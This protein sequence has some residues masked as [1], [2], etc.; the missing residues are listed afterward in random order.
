MSGEGAPAPRAARQRDDLQVENARLRAA[1]AAAESERSALLRFLSSPLIAMTHLRRDGT[2]LF[3]NDVGAQNM[4]GRP[5]DFEGRS[6]FEVIP[7]LEAQTRERI[8][9]TLDTGE[10]LVT[11]SV[12]SLPQGEKWFRSTYYP[13]YD[14]T[15]KPASV[16]LVSQ[17]ITDLKRTEQALEATEHRL[18]GVLEHAPHVVV[19]LDPSGVIR[20]INRAPGG[21]EAR[22]FGSEAASH[23]RPESAARFRAAVERV[24]ATAEPE[25]LE[26][27]DASG[28]Y[29]EVRVAP[30][31]RNGGI[32]QLLAFAVDVSD[33]REAQERERR[34]EAQLL[35]S[36]KLESLGVLAGG[37]AHDFNNL[38]VGVL[39]NAQLAQRHVGT[40]VAG[41]CLGDI[42]RAAQ[43]A[44]ELCKQ[45]LAYAGRGTL[46]LE[47][48]WLPDL[49]EQMVDLVRP[50]MSKRARVVV[51]RD[52][53]VP[54]VQGDATQ[55]Q[56]VVM[57]L[58]TNAS[59]ALGGNDGVVTLRLGE[60]HD[61][62]ELRSPNAL[63]E[64]LSPGPYVYFEVQDTGCGM[65]DDARNRMF[66]PFFS[67]KEQGSGLGLSAVLGIVRRHGGAIHV[68][69]EPG[70]GT[71]I[72]VTLPRADPQPPRVGSVEPVAE[73]TRGTVL[74]VD[75]EPMVRDVAQ[76]TLEAAGHQVLVACDGVEALEVL[77]A[78]GGQVDAV[79]L[80]LTMP[81][82][83][84][85]ETLREL[86]KRNL[87]MPVILASGFSGDAGEVGDPLSPARRFI[88]KPY[89]VDELLRV[90]SQALARGV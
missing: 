85:T 78:E 52:R 34:L 9:R 44:A 3:V 8:E 75:D 46:E 27:E 6:I 7:A 55:L 90:V 65:D 81:R 45:M 42:V 22:L 48:V 28:H 20:Y 33:R 19:V 68:D 54:P 60:T 71:T 62:E 2:I 41:L 70:R 58:L 40:G 72:R 24:L 13:A 32:E 89:D 63:V 12:V 4:G 1:L 74:V 61:D 35:R 36:Q 10:P 16:Q 84:G 17:E 77:A 43:R 53:A 26:V 86:R 29:W 31:Q 64:E 50:S 80:D 73:P 25:L 57:N 38:L 79:L 39:G 23:A 66:D 30:V 83:D 5:R 15:G 82:M 21:D 56:Q 51:E 69:S 47:A 88:A 18:A 87:R 49:C 59:D 11:E 76:R 67:T 14:E 37:I